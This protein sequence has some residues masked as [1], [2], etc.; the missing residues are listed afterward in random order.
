MPYVIQEG[1]KPFDWSDI[2]TK[3]YYFQKF[4]LVICQGSGIGTLEN[5]F[6]CGEVG[7]PGKGFQN[8]FFY[9]TV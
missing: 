9:E 5:E 2:A 1:A 4:T 7:K 8:A 3:M 6:P